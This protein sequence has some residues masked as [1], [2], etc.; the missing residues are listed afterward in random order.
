MLENLDKRVKD[1]VSKLTLEEKVMLLSTGGYEVKRLGIPALGM[2]GEAA[3]G[4]QARHDQSFDRG[5]DEVK[6]RLGTINGQVYTTGFPNPYAMAMS[7]DPELMR[8]IGDVV[9]TE[10]RSLYNEGLHSCLVP[11]A[12]TVEMCRDP[13][14]GRNEEAYGESPEL[15]A[16]MAGAYIDGMHGDEGKQGGYSDFIRVCPTLKHFYGNNVEQGRTT[17]SS[18]ISEELKHSYYMKP[19]ELILRRGGAAVMTSYNAVNG[20]PQTVSPDIQ[21]LRKWGAEHVV[22]DAGAMVQVAADRGYTANDKETVAP[23][24]KHG[25]SMFADDRDA[26]AEAVRGA[27]T[28]GLISKADID[29][30]VCSRIRTMMQLGVMTDYYTEEESVPYGIAKYNLSK[31]NT[32]ESRTLSR[33]AATES[34]V[35]LKNDGLLP[36]RCD[37]NGENAGVVT[38]AVAG[39]AVNAGI[40][41]TTNAGERKTAA[42]GSRRVALLGAFAD[43]TPLDWYSGVSDHTITLREGMEKRFG[44]VEV[45]DMMPEVILTFYDF[46]AREVRFAGLSEETYDVYEHNLSQ[47]VQLTDGDSMEVH[48]L[49]VVDSID[50]AEHFKLMLWDK[51]HITLRSMT[52]GLLVSPLSI[53]DGPRYLYA[54]SKDVYGWFS[55][56]AFSMDI[57]AYISNIYMPEKPVKLEKAGFI[58]HGGEII[59]DTE[60]NLIA[61]DKEDI[62]RNIFDTSCDLIGMCAVLVDDGLGEFRRFM[63]EAGGDVI[64]TAGLHPMVNA[65]EEHDRDGYELPPFMRANIRRIAEEFPELRM[66]LLLLS[67]APVG[68][69]EE[70]DSEAIGAI[71]HT[72]FGSEE[73]GNAIADI[74]SGDVSPAGRLCMTWYKS[75]EDLYDINDYDIINHPRTYRYYDGEPLFSFGYGLSY[76][77]FEEGSDP[78]EAADIDTGRYVI[79]TGSVRS[80]YV[81]IEFEY[82]EELGCKVMTRFKRLYAIEPGEKR[83]IYKE[84]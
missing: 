78:G 57:D 47:N 3:H 39:E 71:L 33:R 68:I 67:G 7:F 26:V 35:L 82:S 60:G 70:Y 80:D 73:L 4:V 1:I 48:R 13:R 74:I 31:V 49:V 22:C 66:T 25:M 64:Y 65:R 9:G 8:K 12:P 84:M 56:E 30:A 72:S 50:K 11:W 79:N 41:D 51:S 76:T 45:F 19:F 28:E 2:G 27:L 61:S 52:T 55:D 46:K 58:S 6:K 34:V 5:R 16:A 23:A 36:L 15:T 54:M 83:Y 75:E 32:A 17:I 38:N 53:D 81:H 43:R 63:E 42:A 59:T 14:W 20:V 18:E 44:H 62:I 10:L 21:Y 24:L 37:S 77:T 40:D 29:V 69:K